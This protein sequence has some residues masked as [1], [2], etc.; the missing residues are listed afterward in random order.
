[1]D[2]KTNPVHLIPS[3]IVFPRKTGVILKKPIMNTLDLASLEFVIT[4]ATIETWGKDSHA[5]IQF[6][7]YYTA[8]IGRH[9]AIKCTIKRGT[10]KEDLYCQLAWDWTLEVWGP[11]VTPMK[12]DV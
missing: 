8:E 1:M 9:G 3:P 11:R 4:L 7:T 2:T 10:Y 6:P 12:K 5:L